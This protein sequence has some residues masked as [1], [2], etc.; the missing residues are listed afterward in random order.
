M[1]DEEEK[2]EESVEEAAEEIE[3]APA[4]NPLEPIA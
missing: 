2:K 4:V 1:M 3:E